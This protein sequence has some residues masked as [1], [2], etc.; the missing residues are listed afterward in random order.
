MQ[1]VC[2]ERRNLK[3]GRHNNNTIRLAIKNSLILR[4]KRIFIKAL[5]IYYFYVDVEITACLHSLLCTFFYFFPI[6]F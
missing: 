2:K 4:F 5:V 1:D 3:I 6:S